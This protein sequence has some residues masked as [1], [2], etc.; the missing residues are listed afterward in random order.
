[1]AM[2]KGCEKKQCDPK[3]PTAIKIAEAQAAKNK[4]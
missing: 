4:K 2:C 1:M 3:C